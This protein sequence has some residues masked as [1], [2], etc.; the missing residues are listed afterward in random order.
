[1]GHKI[2]ID[3]SFPELCDDLCTKTMNSYRTARPNRR[4]MPKIIGEKMKSEAGQQTK[5]RG[6]LYVIVQLVRG[7]LTAMVW[8]DN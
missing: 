3:N 8:T 2:Y 6:K 7:N 4:V 5:V 1:M